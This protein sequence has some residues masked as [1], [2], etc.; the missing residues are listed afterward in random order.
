MKLYGRRIFVA[1]LGVNAVI[2]ERC[3]LCSIESQMLRISDL[4]PVT[5]LPANQL[6]NSAQKHISCAYN[7]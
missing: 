2:K 4:T 6:V 1:T 3:S 5:R 7:K